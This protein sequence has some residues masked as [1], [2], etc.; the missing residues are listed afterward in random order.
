MSPAL[1][2][3]IRKARAS[4]FPVI[5]PVPILEPVVAALIV[6]PLMEIAPKPEVVITTDKRLPWQ[7]RSPHEPTVPSINAIKRLVGIRFN[8]SSVDMVSARRTLDICRPRQIAIYLCCTLTKNSLP[9]IARQ[10][11]KR[12][13]TTALAARD[14]IKGM[15]LSDPGLD[16][17]LNE[18]EGE[19]RA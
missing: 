17:I 9:A 4:H 8:V 13:H 3:A 10:F 12:D 19:L 14:R 16:F 11:G 2:V 7:E 18:L 5:L 6:P 15:R 1:A